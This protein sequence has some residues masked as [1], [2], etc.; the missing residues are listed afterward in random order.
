VSQDQSKIAVAL[1]MHVIKE[2]HK[3]TEIAV[4]K[5]DEDS[6][7]FQLEKLRDFEI[8][9]ACAAFEFSTTDSNNLFFVTSEQLLKLDYSDE[10]KDPEVVYELETPLKH[11]PNSLVFSQDQN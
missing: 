7:E 6:K 10:G 1:G 8:E 9:K 3:I 4:Y 5:K 2:E 11:K